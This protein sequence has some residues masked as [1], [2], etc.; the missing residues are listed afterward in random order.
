MARKILN[1]AFFLLFASCASNSMTENRFTT[2]YASLTGGRYQATSWD[3]RLLLPRYS[4]FQGATL[5]FDAIITEVKPNTPFYQ[6]LAHDVANVSK[7]C[8][9]FSSGQLTPFYLIAIVSLS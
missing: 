3:D 5:Y 2:S 8:T 9:K 6:W 7:R 4:W 1:A